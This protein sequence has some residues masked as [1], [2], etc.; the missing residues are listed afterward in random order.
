[1]D[2]SNK[3]KESYDEGIRIFYENGGKVKIENSEFKNIDYEKSSH[4]RM[5][6]IMSIGNGDEIEINEV[7]IDNVEL[8]SQYLIDLQ[9]EKINA[10]ITN[11]TIQN[12]VLGNFGAIYLGVYLK[13]IYKPVTGGNNVDISNVKIRNNTNGLN[14]SKFTPESI[15]F[16][17]KPDVEKVNVKNIFVEKN[18][19]S[20]KTGEFD[21]LVKSSGLTINQREGMD[22]EV[23]GST[24]AHNQSAGSGG[25][26]IGS[27]FGSADELKI[28]N[29][30]FYA[31]KSILKHPGNTKTGALYVEGGIS[32]GKEHQITNNTFYKNENVRSDNSNILDGKGAAIK[33]DY[34][35]ALSHLTNDL[36]VGNKNTGNSHP[37]KKYENAFF[38]TEDFK[39]ISTLGFDNG[40]V[41]ADTVEGAYGK[42]PVN[43][44]ENGNKKK[45]GRTKDAEVIPTVMIAPNLSTVIGTANLT[46]GEGT[47]VDQR[48]LKRTGKSDIGALEM[49]SVV[50]NANGG[51]FTLA[52][53]TKYDGKTY[54]EGKNPK[55]YAK[56]SGPNSSY[57][58]LDG[59]KVLKPVRTGYDFVG[60][61]DV[62]TAKTPNAKFATGKKVSVEDQQVVYA[63][64]KKKTYSLKYH[65]NG[66]TTGTIPV[67]KNVFST[68]TVTIKS[69][70]KM[71][72]KGYKFSGWST[73]PSAK[74]GEAAYAPGK[75]L[76][77]VKNTKL[78]AIWKR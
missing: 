25:I 21:E 36:L 56:V 12:N 58:M 68:S 27:Q 15:I 5:S 46:G 29:N 75:K 24:F 51:N 13:P 59:K 2:G 63:V 7:L 40:K 50:Y 60:W 53:L 48:G 64:W 76:K 16:I 14:N 62:K 31:N 44:A 43:L 3:P 26:A 4:N 17:D 1:M 55:V 54:Y 20:E 38:E 37:L 74:K 49:S 52:E 41:T 66:K 61:S 18:I 47:E 32:F 22:I 72:R 34:R 73:K 39:L 23:S 67:Q 33:Y 65:S 10:K 70:G 6:P 71:K 69:Q 28:M 11:T 30:T 78:Y 57:T 8:D 35:S 42:Y 9:S 77:L 45:V 19:L